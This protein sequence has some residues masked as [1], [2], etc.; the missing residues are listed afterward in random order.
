MSMGYGFGKVRDERAERA[1]KLA[2]RRGDKPEPPTR[3]K[4]GRP[5]G[6]KN[7]AKS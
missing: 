3:K 1:A 4:G 7:R 5:K 6:S 2:Q